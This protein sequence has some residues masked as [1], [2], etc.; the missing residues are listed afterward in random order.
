MFKDL[1]NNDSIKTYINLFITFLLANVVGKYITSFVD[2]RI[3]ERKKSRINKFE[4][5]KSIISKIIYI[6]DERE[7]DRLLYNIVGGWCEKEQTKKIRELIEFKK[8]NKCHNK[9][10]ELLLL[11]YCKSITDL[12]DM[13][14]PL[15][16][17]N[18]DDQIM[19]NK[20][21]FLEPKE[22]AS[23]VKNVDAMCT[24][25]KEKYDIVINQVRID[26]PELIIVS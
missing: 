21:N 14:I 9:K 16:T 12:Y 22:Y 17:I 1:I 5:D 18:K 8:Y 15:F 11:N 10:T 26:Y 4:T 2:S 25:V 20:D 6:F 3:E 23:I 7:I 19:R 24:N 13:I